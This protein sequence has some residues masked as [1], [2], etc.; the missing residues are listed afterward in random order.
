MVVPIRY[1][2]ISLGTWGTISKHSN[3][4]NKNKSIGDN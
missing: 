3:V 2:Q 4:K 1:I